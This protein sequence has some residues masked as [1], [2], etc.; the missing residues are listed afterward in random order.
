MVVHSTETSERSLL[1][2]RNL[3]IIFSITLMVVMGVASIAPALPA[4]VRDLGISK[5]DVAWL[6]TAFSLPGMLLA[7]FVGVFA[8]RFGRK[9]ILVPAIFLFAIAGTAC[10]F[11]RDFNILLIFRVFQ[12]IGAA[13]MGSINVTLIGDL[14]SGRRRVEAMGLNA[15]VL[16]LGAAGY[17]L[18]G[19]ALAALAWYYPFYLSLIAIPIGIIVLTKLNNPEPDSREDFK[20]YL[21]GAWGYL[22]NMKVAA[23]FAAGVIT[24]I[25]VFGAYLTYFA[26]YMDDAFNVSGFTIGV[27]MS[28][29]ALAAAVVASQMGRITRRIS[30]GMLIKVSFAIF[31]LSLILIPLMPSLWLL[32][33][34]V[35]LLG[36]AQGINLP[37]ILSMAAGLAPTEYR[38]AFMS[39][40]SSMI[41]LGQTVGPPIVGLLYVYGGPTVAF[42]FT[43]GL[44]FMASAVGL[45]A[46]RFYNIIFGRKKACPRI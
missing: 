35:L 46:G 21:V 9:R 24:F 43:A 29:S 34:P 42:A 38:A 36:I 20:S 25:I 16:S 41:R 26:I 23:L 8:D 3:H 45:F 13:A 12:G 4:I 27:F 28:V 31:G 22:K 40:N 17:P 44:A 6:I 33:I 1:R 30:E 18:I 19:G 5:L 39:I 32:L 11:T 2:D 14:Y 37:S 7:P 15:S 10:A